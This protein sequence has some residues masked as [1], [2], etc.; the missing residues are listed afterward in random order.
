M[1]KTV[2]NKNNLIQV[3][4]AEDDYLVSEMVQGLL[5]EM[6]YQVLGV[7]SDGRE[8]VEMAR[9]IKPDVIIMDIQ[10]ADMDGI[11]AAQEIQRHTPIPVVVLTAYETSD[12]V[13]QA[14]QAG[15]GA[16]LIKPPNG[17]ELERAITIAIARHKDMIELQRLNDALREYNEELDAFAHTVAHDLQ[18]PLGLIIG[19]SDL[20]MDGLNDFTPDE[21]REYT[22]VIAQN[23]RKMSQIIDELL[24]LSGVRKMTVERHSFDTGSAVNEALQ[25]LSLMIQERNAQITA[26][27]EWPRAIGYAPWIEEVWVNYLSNALKYGG[28]PPLIELGADRLPGDMVRFWVRDKGPG[29]SKEDQAR[30]FTPFTQLKQVPATGYGLGLSIVQRIVTK[31]GGRTG[32][33]SELGE[34]SLFWF[35]LPAVVKR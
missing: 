4:V 7:A 35:T 17:R 31:L 16:Y 6:G 26:I 25:R 22:V 10:M 28:D 8:V 14:S 15:V 5:R 21:I 32:V 24:L 11:T 34:G 23:G 18:N 30:L 27:S 9:R 3:I 33:E 12:L 20:L 19:F 2:M 29:L 1:E 13:K